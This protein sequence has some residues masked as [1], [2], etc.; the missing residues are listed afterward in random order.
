MLELEL[1]A[2]E[3]RGK[4]EPYEIEVLSQRRQV[5]QGTSRTLTWDIMTHHV[6]PAQKVLSGVDM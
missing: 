5:W 3:L 6:H 4:M 1:A 2:E